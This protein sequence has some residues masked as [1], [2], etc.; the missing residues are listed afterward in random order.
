MGEGVVNFLEVVQIDEYQRHRQLR[1]VGFLHFLA[2][3]LVEHAPVRQAGQGVE[4]GLAPDDVCA[5]LPFHLMAGAVQRAVAQ[6]AFFPLAVGAKEK[7]ASAQ[8]QQQQDRQSA[9]GD[10]VVL[11]QQTGGFRVVAANYDDQRQ[12]VN[13]AVAEDPAQIV[14]MALP[15]GSMN[16]IQ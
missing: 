6:F 4:V 14:A 11:L 8:H 9:A 13:H 15:V 2:Q 16:V 7:M 1:A 10:Q 3:M 5:Q 12:S